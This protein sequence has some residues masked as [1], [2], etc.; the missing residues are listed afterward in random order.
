MV[1]WILRE[2]VEL[3]E[4]NSFSNETQPCTASRGTT[5]YT[6]W[7]SGVTHHRHHSQGRRGRRRRLR[8]C[9]LP[10]TRARTDLQALAEF[11]PFEIHDDRG[12]VG[13]TVLER[14]PSFSFGH[15]I[16]KDPN[17]VGCT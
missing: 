5:Q 16:R 6:Q 15:N 13:K 10:F 2:L 11:P 4:Q 9:P 12:M 14:S 8:A 7:P 1:E 3:S 17:T